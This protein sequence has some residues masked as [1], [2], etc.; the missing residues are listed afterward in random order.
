M[1]GDVF[2]RVLRRDGRLVPYEVRWSGPVDDV[3]PD[4]CRVP[5]RAAAASWRR[6]P[7]EVRRDLRSRLRPSRLLPHGEG[8][9]PPSPRS[10]SP[11]TGCG[12]RWRR[13][14]LE[15]LVGSI[16]AQQVN[17]TFAFALPGAPGAA[18]R[19]AGRHGRRHRVRVSG[20]RARWRARRVRELRAH[21]VLRR[22][23]PSTSAISRA[24]SW[25][26]DA[27]PRRRWRAPPATAS[28]S[29]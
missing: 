5:G 11:S 9:I 1:D 21:A 14:A 6:S 28:S 3:Q 18:L 2:R 26:G 13:R 7:R 17:L 24:R 23:R 10:S 19:H 20:G 12:P 15:M 25:R 16:T 29:S 27:R 8:A 4:A 22:A